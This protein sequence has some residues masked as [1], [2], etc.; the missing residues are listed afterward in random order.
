MTNKLV[1]IAMATYNGEKFLREQLDSI[2]TQT[3]PNLE[4]I[5]CDD[6]STDATISILQEYASKDSR[7][8]I[9]INNQNIGL[10]KNFEKALSLCSGEYIALADQDDI[11]LPKKIE[12]L[13]DN[14]QSFD[15][16]HSNTLL[17]NENS[18]ISKKIFSSYSNKNNSNH[19]LD[20]MFDNNVTG[21]TA[22][23]KRSL[24][25]DN[26]PF[27]NNVCL[28]D[29]WLAI[30]A[31]NKNGVT[32]LQQPLTYYRQ[33]SNNQVGATSAYHISHYERREKNLRA[34]ILLLKTIQ[35]YFSMDQQTSD[36]IYSLII[37][38]EDFFSKKIR[39]Q[40]FIFHCIHFNYL[41]RKKLFIYRIVALFLSFFGHKIQKKLWSSNFFLQ[42]INK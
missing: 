14:I 34:H 13:R 16:I 1:S 12:I 4:I 30:L 26:L 42:K 41:Y 29:Y 21:C 33:H 36:F 18:V 28:H 11:W 5:I 19:F 3:Y 6:A 20:Y 37:Y 10:V 9:F 27:P 17:I 32:Y 22:L 39:L 2:L 40:S 23:F 7:I 8:N 25:D 24:L 38:H 31:A 35:N 15:L